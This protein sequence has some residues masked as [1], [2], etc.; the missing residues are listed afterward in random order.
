MQVVNVQ[1]VNRIVVALGLVV[2]APM[3]GQ[4]IQ[5]VKSADLVGTWVDHVW[6]IQSKDRPDSL[7]GKTTAQIWTF[8]ADSTYRL[9]YKWLDG[10]TW[11]TLEDGDHGSWKFAGETL[12]MISRG[13]VSYVP[14]YIVRKGQQLL[15]CTSPARDGKDCG[16][17]LEPFDPAKPLTPPA[18]R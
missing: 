4:A 9:E 3:L 18:P 7:Q 15:G 8:N 11:R 10:K 16:R 13:N 5:P 6:V 1:V 2:P 14:Q 12:Q 17:T